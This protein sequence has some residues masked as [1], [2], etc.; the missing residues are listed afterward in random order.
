MAL[1]WPLLGEMGHF[2]GSMVHPKDQSKK[3]T[4]QIAQVHPK[5]FFFFPNFSISKSFLDILLA[6]CQKSPLQLSFVSRTDGVTSLTSENI[7]SEDLSSPSP[8]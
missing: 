7:P 1:Q 4:Q 2:L 6:L 3:L 8:S 5:Y